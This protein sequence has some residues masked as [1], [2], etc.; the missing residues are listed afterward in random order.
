MP[1]RRERNTWWMHVFLCNRDGRLVRLTGSGSSWS[2]EHPL[3]G[4]GV[5]CVAAEGDVVLVGLLGQGARL[6]TDAGETWE[7]VELPDAEVFSVAIGPAD[8]ALYVGTEPSRLF[9]SHDGGT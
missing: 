3:E 1:V 7:P 9:V 4:V 6:S 8:G 5:R 2:V